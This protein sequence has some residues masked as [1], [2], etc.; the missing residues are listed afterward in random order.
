MKPGGGVLGCV[1]ISKSRSLLEK[2]TGTTHHTRSVLSPIPLK[3]TTQSPFNKNT[4]RD[5]KRVAVAV[6]NA[7]YDAARQLATAPA[8][9]P[10]RLPSRPYTSPRPTVRTPVHPTA[11]P[12]HEHPRASKSKQ[13]GSPIYDD[14]TWAQDVFVYVTVYATSP[15]VCHALVR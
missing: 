4:H 12:H 14:T 6:A 11:H 8:A 15:E 2:G 1:Y 7:T 13:G 9:V 10:T 5:G 3:H